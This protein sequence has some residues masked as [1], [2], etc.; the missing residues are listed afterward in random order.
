MDGKRVA[1]L[2]WNSFVHDARVS[3]EAETL[4]RSGARVQVTAVRSQPRLRCRE[5]TE[6]GIDVHRVERSSRSITRSVFLPR[7]LARWSLCLLLRGRKPPVVQFGPLR[8]WQFDRRLVFL[9]EELGVNWKMYRS[10]RAFAPDVVHAH[11]VNTLVPAWLAARHCRAR[12][13]YDAHELSADREGYAGRAW[14]A[15]LVERWFGNAADGRVTTTQARAAWFERAYAYRD[16]IVLQNRPIR[17]IVHGSGR[18]RAHCGIPATRVIVLYQGG[19]Q[20][21]RG[22][23]NLVEAMR[24]LPQADLVFVGDGAERPVLEAA[25]LAMAGRVHFVGQV[26]LDEL[27]EW[28]ASADIGVQTLRNTCLN[29][30]T[31]DSNKLFEYVMGGLPVVASDFPEIRAIVD[32]WNLG[33]LVDPDDVTALREALRRLIDDEA[34]RRTYAGNAVR[35]RDHLDWA[36]QAPRLLAL[37]AS[38]CP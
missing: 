7:F 6:S 12:L 3:R 21:G 9:L 8:W 24:G 13:V 15:K 5:R 17:R 34:E 38:I 16:M 2:V 33:Y 20:W 25:S 22:L 27:P 11:D 28:T 35:A 19:L 31:T 18:I 4:L 14:L 1:M 26:P 32:E 37:Y 29:H 30:Y 10:A 36:S 23:R